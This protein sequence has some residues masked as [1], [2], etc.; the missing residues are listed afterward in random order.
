[1]E[2]VRR[3]YEFTLS[4]GI[5]RIGWID[6]YPGATNNMEGCA[7]GDLTALAIR[8]TDAGM[9]DYWDDVDAIA[10]NQLVEAQFADPVELRRVAEAS[11]TSKDP[12]A[13]RPGEADFDD[14]IARSLGI[15]VG[16][17]TPVSCAL[18][19]SMLC[20]TGN[21]TQGLYYAWESIVREDGDRAQVNLLLNRAARLLDVDSWLPFEGKVVLRNKA[22]RRIAVRIPHWVDRRALQ[23]DVNGRPFPLDWTGN[24]LV[25][26]GLAPRDAIT[27]AFPVPVSTERYTVNANTDR[28]VMYTCTFRGSTCV[29]ISPRDGAPA[30]YHFYR[31]DQM[32]GARAPMKTVERFVAERVVRDW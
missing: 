8:L 27:L 6:C 4:Q 26:A 14:V 22:A 20:C 2:F 10:R 24:Y 32:K 30:S 5:A 18:P 21:G 19:W 31:R 29:D 15:F 3:G 9:G 13:F 12:K 17:F 1:M 7:T 25:F 28:E 23:A 11:G 16:L